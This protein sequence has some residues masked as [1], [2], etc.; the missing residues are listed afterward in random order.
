[1]AASSQEAYNKILAYIDQQGGAYSAW[2]CGITSD[3]KT[4]LFSQHNVPQQNYPYIAVDCVNAAS[5][6]AVEKALLDLG[7]QGGGGGG[8][9]SS[10]FAYAYL[11][12]SL[13]NP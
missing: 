9:E 1:M 2:Y 7:C 12:G 10:R 3:H 11:T 13:T 4:R 8:D 5:A 6:R